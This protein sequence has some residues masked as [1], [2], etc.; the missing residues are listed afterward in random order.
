M[1]VLFLMILLT[2]AVGA[3]MV[4][5]ALQKR[6]LSSRAEPR[7]CA[8]CGRRLDGRHCPNCMR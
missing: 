1:S 2:T 6:L 4:R 7:R 3:A 5:M 8:S